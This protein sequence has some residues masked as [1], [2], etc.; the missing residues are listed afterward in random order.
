MNGN[1]NNPFSMG[2]ITADLFMADAAIKKQKHCQA[3]RASSTEA[4]QDI[5]CSK[6]LKN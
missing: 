4:W 5:I 6:R 3:R 1:S 2:Q